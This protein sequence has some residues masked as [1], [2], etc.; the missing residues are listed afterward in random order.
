MVSSKSTTSGV[1]LSSPHGLLVTPWGELFVA[2]ASANAIRRF[3]LTGGGQPIPAGEITGN[4]LDL[5]F[6]LVMT[7]WD[8]LFVTNGAG[9]TISRFTFDAA[10]VATPRDNF[11]VP[12][13]ASLAWMALDVR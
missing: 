4:G 9:G 6:D 5:P 13:A 7:P 10:H 11:E 8:E 1:A 12:D 2:N 3:M